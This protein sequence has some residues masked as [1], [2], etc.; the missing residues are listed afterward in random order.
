M[1]GGVRGKLERGRAGAVSDLRVRAL[2][3]GEER[4]AVTAFQ[5]V[6]S[7]VAALDGVPQ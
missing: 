7:H 1:I 4:F 3:H 6:P 5:R 2:E